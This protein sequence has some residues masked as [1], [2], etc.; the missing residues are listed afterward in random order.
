ML[1]GERG[2][3]RATTQQAPLAQTSRA[4]TG[5]NLGQSELCIDLIIGLELAML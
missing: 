3:T 5:S 1:I 4:R 2:R